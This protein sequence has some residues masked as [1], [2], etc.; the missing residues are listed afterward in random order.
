MISVIVPVYK[1]EKY[2]PRCVDSILA[3]TY[4]DLEIILVDDGSPDNCGEICDEYA[5]KDSRIKVIHKQNGGLSDARNVGIEAAKG[6]YISFIDSDDYIAID[7]IATLYKLLIDNS[8]EMSKV[9]YKTVYDD[10]GIIESKRKKEAIV[11]TNHDVER[12]FLDL[13]IDSSCVFLYSRELI[14]NTRFIE[15][16]TSE[17]ILFNFEIFKKAKKFVYL[18]TEKYCYYYNLDSISN[19]CFNKNMLNYLNFRKEIYDFYL[20]KQDLYM[21]NK[22]EALYA[23]AAMGLMARIAL[24]GIEKGL[25]EQEYKEIMKGVFKKHK[26][27]FFKDKEIAISRKMLAVLVFYFYPITKFVKRFV[28]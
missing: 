22:S 12:A 21:I 3:Q 5:L 8:A 20:Q 2:L 25:S 16:K 18:P 19:G 9:N 17:D 7:Y 28:K 23:K 13:K 6:E 26:S 14:G 24:Y 1:V 27:V 10:R 15:G 4:K 11:Y